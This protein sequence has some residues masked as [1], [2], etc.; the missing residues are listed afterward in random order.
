M[1]NTKKT[2][3]VI[4]E[5]EVIEKPKMTQ[6]VT[7]ERHEI[8]YG[9]YFQLQKPPIHR[10]MRAYLEPKYRGIIKSI[11]RWDTELQDYFAIEE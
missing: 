5:P 1:A 8:S 11:D 7:S 4:K 9:K 6:E 3:K 2:A 10:Y